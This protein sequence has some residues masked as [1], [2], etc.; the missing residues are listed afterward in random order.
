MVEFRRRS[1]CNQWDIR[2]PLPHT[3]LRSDTRSPHCKLKN[4]RNKTVKQ[5][6]RNI[7]TNNSKQIQYLATKLWM[8]SQGKGVS[9]T[10]W[11]RSFWHDWVVTCWSFESFDSAFTDSFRVAYSVD[12]RWSSSAARNTYKT[13]KRLSQGQC[14]QAE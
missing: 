2:T 13:T 4:P 3:C 9:V 14:I 5:R 10:S 11:G 7:T 12:A 8:T 6:S 1:L